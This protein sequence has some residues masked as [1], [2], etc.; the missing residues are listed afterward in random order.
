M[1]LVGDGEF[2]LSSGRKLYANRHIIGLRPDDK[3]V[4]GGY[5]DTLSWGGEG[6]R[7]DRSS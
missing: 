3:T 6:H 7:W 4:Y 5:D 2:V 1:R